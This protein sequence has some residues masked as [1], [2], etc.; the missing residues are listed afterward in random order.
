M[1][2]II[3]LVGGDK[4]S[5][6][7]LPHESDICFIIIQWIKIPLSSLTCIWKEEVWKEVCVKKNSEINAIPFQILNKK[8][9]SF[10]PC[11]R[12]YSASACIPRKKR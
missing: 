12:S 4:V 5:Y 10:W 2:E 9:H 7:I 8:N 11:S 6:C 3:S 1:N